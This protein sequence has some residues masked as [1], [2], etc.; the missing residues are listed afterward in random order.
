MIASAGVGFSEIRHDHGRRSTPNGDKSL[1]RAAELGGGTGFA[2]TGGVERGA[3]RE[4]DVDKGPGGKGRVQ[5]ATGLGAATVKK[6][7]ELGGALFRHRMS[8]LSRVATIL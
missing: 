4:E 6:S 7:A 3:I 2:S 8:P 5:V 1:A